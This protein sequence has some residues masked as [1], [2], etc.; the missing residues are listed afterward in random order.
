LQLKKEI[1]TFIFLFGKL[2]KFNYIEET[3]FFEVF[4]EVWLEE[5]RTN[6]A[7]SQYFYCY[8]ITIY[9][10]GGVNAKV[11]HR[12]WKI[13]DG[14]ETHNIEG[15]GLGGTTPNIKA[16][17]LFRHIGFLPLKSPYG[18]MRGRLQLKLDNGSYLWIKV[19]LF[20]LRPE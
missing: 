10:K 2:M 5:S 13:N 3:D 1:I 8:W 9:N 17:E 18:N 20:F 12:E 15:F 19:P 4:V 16:G 6:I 7:N 11:I 14:F